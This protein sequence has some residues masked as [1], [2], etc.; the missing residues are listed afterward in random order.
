MGERGIIR[1]FIMENISMNTENLALDDDDNF[2]EKRI[3]NSLFAMKLVT[4]VEE[5]FQVIIENEDLNLENFSTIN[6]LMNL[7]YK[8]KKK[9]NES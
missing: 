9:G 6:R 5:N 2:F 7:I 3:V 4:F 8:L 1:E